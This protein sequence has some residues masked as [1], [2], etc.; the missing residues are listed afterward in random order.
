[1]INHNDSV[2]EIHTL[3]F[4]L[5]QLQELAPD[6]LALAANPGVILQ[7]AIGGSI[8]SRF[9]TVVAKIHGALAPFAEAA[10]LQTT[11]AKS[12]DAPAGAVEAAAANLVVLKPAISTQR[13][14]L[15]QNG[16]PVRVKQTFAR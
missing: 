4:V 16:R 12:P 13:P 6:A 9:N 1:M 10:N 15:E 2:S 11:A 8:Q 14:A 7:D 5:V 3:E